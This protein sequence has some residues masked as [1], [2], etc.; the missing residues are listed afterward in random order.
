M[1][2]EELKDA[3]E[4]L[5]EQFGDTC[6]FVTIGNMLGSLDNWLGSQTSYIQFVEKRMK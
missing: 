4:R 1:T 6:D 5:I 2:Y 3:A